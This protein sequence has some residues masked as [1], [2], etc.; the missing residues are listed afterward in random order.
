MDYKH[1]AYNI[2]YT[3]CK[4][5]EKEIVIWPVAPEKSLI[6]RAKNKADRIREM[7]KLFDEK[8]LTQEEYEKEKAKILDEK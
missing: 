5:Q 2:E 3:G 7:K 6:E 8:I 4:T 1:Y